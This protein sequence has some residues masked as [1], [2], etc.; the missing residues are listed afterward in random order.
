MNSIEVRMTVWELNFNGV[1]GSIVAVKNAIVSFFK[2]RRNSIEDTKIE[3]VPDLTEAHILKGWYDR[4]GQKITN[5]ISMSK[6]IDS[7]TFNTFQYLSQMNMNSFLIDS[8]LYF[9]CRAVIVNTNSYWYKSC[10][11]SAIRKNLGMRAMLSINV[12]IAEQNR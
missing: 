7:K 12:I 3:Y 4:E 8:T 2:R 11:L 1:K 9:N 6:T 10:G 5:I